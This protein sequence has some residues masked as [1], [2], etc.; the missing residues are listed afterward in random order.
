M[1]ISGNQQK[2]ITRI[3][4]NQGIKR[5][6]AY[7]YVALSLV[8]LLIFEIAFM[9][10]VTNYYYGNVARMISYRSEHS[11]QFYR[12]Y[13]NSNKY[14]LTDLAK[15]MVKD[16]NTKNEEKMELQ[17]IDNT[18]KVIVSSTGFDVEGKV[19]TPDFSEAVQGNQSNWRG[20]SKTGEKVM[21]NSNPIKTSDGKVEGVIRYV[22]SLE[23]IERT[24]QKVLIVS[25]FIIIMVLIGMLMISFVFSRS[26]IT[27]IKEITS[28]A[29]R[30]AE[31]QF[32]ERIESK[33]N[34]EIGELADTLNYMAEEIV[35]SNNLKNEFISSISHELRTPLTSIRGWGETILT[36]DFEDKE[37]ARLGLKIIVKETARLSNMVE[38]LLDFSKMERG[39]IVLYL[40]E[41]NL[42]S[43]LEEVINITKRR[44]E[45]EGI[46]LIYNKQE[47]IPNILGDTNR[48]KQ[49]FLNVIDNAIK[50]TESGKSVE[51]DLRSDE[52]HVYVD[53]IDEGIGIPDTD[54][55]FVKEKFFKGKSKKSGSGIGLAISSEI[56]ELHKGKLNVDSS[57]GKGTSIILVFPKIT[58]KETE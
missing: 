30:M 17:V 12:S 22:V 45:Q 48:L 21:S 56:M 58:P 57:E 31:G 44:A 49:V 16:F 43:E 54:I 19:D 32:S 4:K 39:K 47:D 55:N 11:T 50:F 41:I 1:D 36:G 23:P 26:I 37:E 53:I 27:P 25:I 34:D 13:I 29:R 52:E 5:R 33:Y 42:V 18:G 35:I 7:S 10:F 8:I 46:E 28:V 3:I 38:E 9:L 15:Q 40:E 2:K 6:W 20:T 14:D 51:V 24:I